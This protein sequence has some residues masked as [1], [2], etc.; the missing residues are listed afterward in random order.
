MSGTLASASTRERACCKG[1][2]SSQS[3]MVS[4]MDNS[5]GPQ[6]ADARHVPSRIRLRSSSR[7]A[8]TVGQVQRWLALLSSHPNEEAT[9]ERLREVFSAK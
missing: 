7:M 3:K 5:N 2:L 6:P 8:V 4:S 1:G 9:R